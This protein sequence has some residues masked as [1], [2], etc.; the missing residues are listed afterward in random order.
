MRAFGTTIF[1]EMSALAVRTVTDRAKEAIEPIVDPTPPALPTDL[2]TL[3]TG[4]PDLPTDIPDLPTNL[5]DL[6]DTGKKIT[7]VYEVTGDGPAEIVYTE[8]LGELPRRIRAKLPWKRK[9]TMT[10]AALVSVTAVR[11]ATDSGAIGCRVT[12]AGEVVAQH[13]GK[14]R[15]ATVSCTKI[16]LR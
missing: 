3:P 12:V 4:I 15:L 8:K 5:P 6:P 9:T 11:S 2:P 1:S 14:G 16:I 7:V 10:G 13:S